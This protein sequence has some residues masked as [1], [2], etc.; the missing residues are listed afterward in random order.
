MSPTGSGYSAAFAASWSDQ[1]TSSSPPDAILISTISLAPCGVVAQNFD[2]VTAS[3]Y[4]KDV[5]PYRHST[6]TFRADTTSLYVLSSIGPRSVSI[7]FAFHLC[8]C[9]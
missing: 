8:A 5:S 1:T 9:L 4:V 3:A 2:R 6:P 7:A